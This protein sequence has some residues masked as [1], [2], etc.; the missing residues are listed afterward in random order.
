MHQYHDLIKSV[1]R[2]GSYKPNRTG[3][4][5]VSAFGQHYSVDLQ[6]GFPLLTTKQMD[7]Y[8]WKSL[9]YELLWY[10][11]GEQHIRQLRRNTKIWDAWADDEGHLD[12]AYGRF[13]RRYPVPEEDSQLPGEAWPDAD[14]RWVT[15]EHDY[16][17]TYGADVLSDDTPADA[18]RERFLSDAPADA[19]IALN[20][21]TVADDESVE[22][23]F[24]SS[25]A[26]QE[27]EPQTGIVYPESAHFENLE[28]TNPG[29]PRLV[30]D[31]IEY[32]LDSLQESPESRRM[33]VNAW[34]PANA[35]V[36][37]L[38][39][40]H[41]SF[42]FNVQGDTLNTH[43]TQRSGDV[44][45]GI[46]FNIACYALITHIVAQ[47]TGF[48]VG[49]FSHT[50]V[51]AHIYCGTGERGEWYGENLDALQSLLKTTEKS[52]HYGLNAREY[53][54]NEPPEEAEGEEGYDHFPG[55]LEQIG[56]DTLSRPRIEI[57]DKPLDALE[58]DDIQLHEYESHDGINFSVAE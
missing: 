20:N 1:L 25:P 14:C 15:E 36:S 40:C 47:Q 8:R 21:V 38:P 26:V 28:N 24:S 7:G 51:D 55:L 6:D 5:T 9:I 4:D 22:V 43:L 18:A 44:A 39:P 32:V 33:V 48:E 19:R 13:W 2:E 57:A 54:E 34:H 41:Y 58:Y 49:S 35:G 30:F 11:S 3:V 52:R 29:N 17:A 46:P 45:L 50:I 10:F 37:T 12:T 53:I 42:V 27:G 16:I 31:Q 56:R 23:A